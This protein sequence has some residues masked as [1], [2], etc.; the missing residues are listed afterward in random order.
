MPKTAN[1]FGRSWLNNNPPREED[2]RTLSGHLRDLRLEP[3]LLA[4]IANA[5]RRRRARVQR[6]TR[7]TRE[8]GARA[9]SFR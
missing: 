7:P 9:A 6:G 5:S 8:I 1:S 2:S 3:E 4:G